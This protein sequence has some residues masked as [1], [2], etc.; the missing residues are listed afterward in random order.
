MSEEK[1]WYKRMKIRDMSGA[2]PE[3]VFFRPS[4]RGNVIWC[5][6]VNDPFWLVWE[7]DED[8]IS[9]P[10][11][12]G[13]GWTDRGY[14]ERGESLST[15]FMYEHTFICGI[16]KPITSWRYSDIESFN[17]HVDIVEDEFHKPVSDKGK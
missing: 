17:K 16:G 5:W 3:N 8:G 14:E 12:S 11:C 10:K 6:I 9:C 7:R 1:E 2:K 4:G 13:C 15:A